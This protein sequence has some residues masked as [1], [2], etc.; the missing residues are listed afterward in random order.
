[1]SQFKQM[2]NST[3]IILQMLLGIILQE[4]YGVTVEV[5]ENCTV[6]NIL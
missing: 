4:F 1:M 6:I 3:P 5:Y 2:R